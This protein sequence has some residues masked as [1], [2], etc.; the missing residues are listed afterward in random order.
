VFV[1]AERLA[2]R[3]GWTH[4]YLYLPSTAGPDVAAGLWYALQPK[5]TLAVAGEDAIL[6]NIPVA[7]V[8]RSTEDTV[9]IVHYVSRAA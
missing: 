4:R 6:S 3:H 2:R 7:E 9:P 8:R 5:E 1:E